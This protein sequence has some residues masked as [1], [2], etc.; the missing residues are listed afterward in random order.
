MR[1]LWMI[2][3][4]I[5]FV[6]TLWF[7]FKSVGSPVSTLE[8]PLLSFVLGAL[9]FNII[10]LLSHFFF[11]LIPWSRALPRNGFYRYIPP[12]GGDNGA[13]MEEEF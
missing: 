1:L 9:V 3:G 2:F 6:W 5:Y 13:A 4:W 12:G 7:C 11:C 10:L 8:P